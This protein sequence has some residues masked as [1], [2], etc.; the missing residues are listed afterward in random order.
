[1]TIS[2]DVIF[3]ENGKWDSKINKNNTWELVNMSYD[4]PVIGVKWVYKA[5]LNL[6]GSIQKNKAKLVVKEYAQKVRSGLQ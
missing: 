5:K 3:D 1:M 4:K 2:R 6:D